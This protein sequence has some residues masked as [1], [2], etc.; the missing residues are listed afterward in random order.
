[1]VARARAGTG[2]G[3]AVS[4][5][6]VTRRGRPCVVFKPELVGLRSSSSGY[7]TGGGMTFV[8]LRSRQT[9]HHLASTSGLSSAA[10]GAVVCGVLIQAVVDDI[11]STLL[12]LR[13]DAWVLQ[14]IAAG[15]VL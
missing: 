3:I 9:L 7:G 15:K 10:I 6:A 13:I 4:C 5:E 14:S 11:W 2:S 1:M 8:R 12:L